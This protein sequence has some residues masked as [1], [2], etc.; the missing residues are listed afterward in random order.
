MSDLNNSSHNPINPA[1]LKEVV[2]DL[3]V[4]AVTV[5][6]NWASKEFFSMLI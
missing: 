1:I 2:N 5:S 3:L 4:L 6:G